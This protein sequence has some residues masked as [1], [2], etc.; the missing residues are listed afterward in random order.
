MQTIVNHTE[1]IFFLFLS[2][3]QKIWC[4]MYV[5]FYI[6]SIGMFIA[7]WK[8]STLRL[9]V[10]NN[11][12]MFLL[13]PFPQHISNNGW[14]KIKL[15]ALWGWIWGLWGVTKHPSR[16]SLSETCEESIHLNLCWTVTNTLCVLLSHQQRIN[17]YIP[18]FFYIFHRCQ[19]K[20]FSAT[21]PQTSLWCCEDINVLTLLVEFR[22]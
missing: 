20:S 11:R 21:F 3:M 16:R 10:P 13:V 2:F 12:R 4:F 18:F 17:W 14:V 9:C 15:K 19:S 6:C 7:H 5:F 8:K 22:F 1:H